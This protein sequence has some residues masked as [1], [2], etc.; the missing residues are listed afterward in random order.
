MPALRIQLRTS[1]SSLSRNSSVLLK[2][3]S[4]AADVLSLDLGV[5]RVKDRPS[6]YQHHVG[7]GLEG[8]SPLPED[9]PQQPLRAVSRNGAP[10]LPASDEA[11]PEPLSRAREN[12]GYEEGAHPSSSLP[13][14]AL[15]VRP[16]AQ[17]RSSSASS[18]GPALRQTESRCRPFRRRRARTARPA[19]DRILTRKPWVRL[20]RRRFG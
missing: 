2:P 6:R 18:S 7:R 10:D 17:G 19:L 16:A 5:T 13:I 9:L 14:D 3:S 12:E 8:G 11:H 15:E 20:R 4:H 1:L